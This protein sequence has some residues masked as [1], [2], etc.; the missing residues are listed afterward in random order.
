MGVVADAALDDEL[1]VTAEFFVTV[2]ENCRV[3]VQGYCVI[4]I[5][6]HMNDW[7]LSIR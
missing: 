1:Y 3:F 5:A 2:F 6:H 4:L 7:D